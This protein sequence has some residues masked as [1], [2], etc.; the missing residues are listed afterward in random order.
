MT[1]PDSWV[2]V[3]LGDVCDIK[4]GKRLPKGIALTKKNTGHPYIRVRDMNE[5]G[6]DKDNIMYVPEK[7]INSINNYKVFKNDLYIS[8]A[9]TL[10]LVGKVTEDFDGANL[11]ENADRLTKISINVDYLLCVLKSSIIKSQIDSITTV[12]AQPKLALTRLKE[13]VVPLPPLAEQKRI[14]AKIEACFAQSDAIAVDLN[15]ATVLLKKFREAVLAKAF[16][17]ELVAREPDTEWQEVRLGDVCAFEYGKPLKKENRRDGSYPVFGSNGIVGYHDSYLVKAPFIV[18][19]RK[20]S[21]GAVNFSNKDGFPIDTTFYIQS[22][23]KINLRFLYL[24]LMSLNLGSVNEQSAV[25]GLNRNDAYKLKI[26]LPPL[27]EQKRIVAK[28][29][30]CFARA[31][32]IGADI[33][34]AT[35]LLQKFREAVLVKAFAGELVPQEASEGTGHELLQKIARGHTHGQK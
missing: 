9:G 15:K 12:S 3:R 34:K 18:V 33:D 10:G 17:G 26:P 13:F 22:S 11:T 6:I 25:P 28:I 32:A 2:E 7:I 19:G 30:A 16:A 5:N 8:V 23:D 14:V 20:G 29:E 27:A 4:G 31:E 21:A 35:V 1:I 24:N